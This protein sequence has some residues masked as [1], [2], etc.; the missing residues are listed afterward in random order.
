MALYRSV[1]KWFD[2]KKG[3]GFIVHPDDGRDI[4]AHYS[5]IATDRRFRTL[6]TGQQ[7]EYE[8]KEGPKGLHAVSIRPLEE[9]G[10]NE[11]VES[12]EFEDRT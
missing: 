9:F 1:V 5:Q 7:V 11:Q 12:G 4:F 6:R 2:S 8:L 10:E 3:Y